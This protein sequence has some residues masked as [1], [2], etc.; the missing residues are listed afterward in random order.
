LQYIQTAML[1]LQHAAAPIAAKP[2]CENIAP[3]SAPLRRM[4]P[5]AAEAAISTH[6][7]RAQQARIKL[8][9]QNS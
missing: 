1:L 8:L 6:V 2:H 7:R 4:D 9:L 3:S 5:G